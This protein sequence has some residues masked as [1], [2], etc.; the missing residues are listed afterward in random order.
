M[1]FTTTLLAWSVI[2]FGHSMQN[3]LENAKEALRWGTDYLLKAATATPATLYVQVSIK[4]YQLIN[5]TNSTCINVKHVANIPWPEYGDA[6]PLN[7]KY[8]NAPLLENMF[9]T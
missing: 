3:Q 1:A 9:Q 5:T 4:Q 2:E 8:S 7:L 6:Y